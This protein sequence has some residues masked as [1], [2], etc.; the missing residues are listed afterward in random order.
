EPIM[1]VVLA[2][3]VGTIVLALF[4]PLVKIIQGMSGQ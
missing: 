2:I 1:I 4:M 3:V